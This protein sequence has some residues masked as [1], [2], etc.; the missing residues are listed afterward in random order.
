[1][2]GKVIDIIT[3]VY[4]DNIQNVNSII[5]LLYIYLIQSKSQERITFIRGKQ[6]IATEMMISFSL[7]K[8]NFTW[9]SVKLWLYIKF[10]LSKLETLI[11]RDSFL[12]QTF[13]G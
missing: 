3:G 7:I 6:R 10:S 2:I 11:I 4:L 12:V 8:Y 1:M 9:I 5:W 13:C